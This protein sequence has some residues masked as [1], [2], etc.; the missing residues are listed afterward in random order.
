M[1]TLANIGHWSGYLLWATLLSVST[2]TIL[3]SLPGGWVA[4][5]LAVLYDLCYGFDSIG[6]LHLGIFAGLLGVGELIEAGLG[7]LYVA[8]KGATRY[9][10]IGGFLGGFVGAIL[11]SS[12]VAVVGTVIGGFLGAFLGAVLGEYMRDQRL[13]PSLRIGLHATLGKIL[14]VSVKFALAMAGAGWVIA[15]GVPA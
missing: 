14:S 7:T 5:G 6:F 10:M 12:I 9:G 15:R 4:L 3:V 1:E 11:G 13:E 2:A 8:K